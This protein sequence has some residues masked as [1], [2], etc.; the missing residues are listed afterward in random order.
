MKGSITLDSTPNIGSKATF[1]IPLR[2]SS[3]CPDPNLAALASSPPNPG[4]RLS[5]KPIRIPSWE[6]PFAH[7]SKNQDLLNQQISN[8]MTNYPPIHNS[9][10]QFE[11]SMMRQGSLNEISNLNAMLSVEERSNVHVLVVEDKYV[12]PFF[13]SIINVSYHRMI[14]AIADCKSARST[15]P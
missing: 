4:F 5:T 7:R 6:K 8:S 12:S 9:P 15:R 11:R 1:T 13:W 10:P 14:G 3:W 2:V